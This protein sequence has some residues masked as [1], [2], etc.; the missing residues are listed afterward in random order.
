MLLQ[1]PPLV[2][3]AVPAAVEARSASWCPN[4]VSADVCA[5]VAYIFRSHMPSNHPDRG[6]A[7]E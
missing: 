5:A 4:E 3:V 7:S 2:A 6:G 1:K